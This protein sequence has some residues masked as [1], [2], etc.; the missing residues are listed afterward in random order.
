MLMRTRLGPARPGRPSR[1][2]LTDPVRL[3]DPRE[4]MARLPRGSVVMLRDA[5]PP[6]ARAVARLCRI[7]S[8]H[9]LV[10]GD[11]RLALALKA[12]LH[13]PD[14]RETRGL[15]PFLLNRRGRMLSVAVHGRRGVSAARRLRATRALVSP[16]FATA[17]HPGAPGLG[18]FRWASLARHL[19]CPT[20]AL[21]GMD[22]RRARSLPSRL[23]AGWAAI[24]AFV[25]SSQQ[26][27]R[28]V[29][30]SL[31]RRLPPDGA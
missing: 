19:G 18:V 21:G 3:P 17:S 24:G 31:P 30:Q 29:A 28:D 15:L 5:S 8:L 1:W 12:G 16:A 11:G 7:R 10:A 4:A 20:V 9:L 26:C 2:L 27:V 14:R 6:T 13:V 22:G 23:L 25:L